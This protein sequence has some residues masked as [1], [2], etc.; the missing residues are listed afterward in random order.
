[1]TKVF[2]Y[3]KRRGLHRTQGRSDL[4]RKS[5]HLGNP[6]F[7]RDVAINYVIN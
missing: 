6:S 4:G 7:P 1:M 5:V 2:G 3:L